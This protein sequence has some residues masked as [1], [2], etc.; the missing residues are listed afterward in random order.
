[1]HDNCIIDKNYIWVPQLVISHRL[2]EA[3]NW[4]TG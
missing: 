3:L 2:M 4:F 1:L